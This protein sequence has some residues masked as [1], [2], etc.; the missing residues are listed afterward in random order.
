MTGHRDRLDDGAIGREQLTTHEIASGS[1]KLC[2]GPI[3]A[4][5]ERDRTTKPAANQ[6]VGAEALRNTLL[7][8][9]RTQVVVVPVCRLR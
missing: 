7:P 9:C 1:S 5:R 3:E 2:I 6:R 4:T 8:R